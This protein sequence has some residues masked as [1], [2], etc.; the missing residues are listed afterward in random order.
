MLL[1]FYFAGFVAVGLAADAESLV[2]SISRDGADIIRK[3]QSGFGT[4][5]QCSC[6]E[7]AECVEEMKRQA[8]ECNRPCFER[9]SKVTDRVDE[10]FTC[11]DAKADIIERFLGCF[12][13]QVD[14]CIQTSMG[15]QIPKTNISN[16]FTL[17]QSALER[18]DPTLDALLSPIKHIL[19]SAGEWALCLKE[20]FLGR[21]KHGFC[22]DRKGCQP[23]LDERKAQRS[24][25][26]CT[27]RIHWKDQAGDLCHCSANAGLTELN[28]YCLL[29]DHM[30]SARRHPQRG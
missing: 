9:F 13:H 8:N 26:R 6:A 12:E 22:F 5:R 28:Q 17:A 10:L 24:F 20:C 4:V 30:K 3:A 18:K 2:G 27:H 16:L 1:L 19:D 15:P 14:G 29:F 7:Q 23:K 21:N 11:F 25:K